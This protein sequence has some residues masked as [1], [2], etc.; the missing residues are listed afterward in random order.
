MASRESRCGSF[1]AAT[2]VLAS[3]A[4][5]QPFS[6]S[7]TVVAYLDSS[8]PGFVSDSAPADFLD[9]L[10]EA[11]LFHLDFG[12][13]AEGARI[14]PWPWLGGSVP[15]DRFSSRVTFSSTTAS[16]PFSSSERVL[17]MGISSIDWEIGPSPGFHGDLEL[18]FEG[19]GAA[20][21]GFGIGTVGFGSD[22]KITLYDS[23][24][25]LL[26]SFAGP[27]GGGFGFAGFV[28]TGAERIARAEIEGGDAYWAIQDVSFTPEPGTGVLLFFG[29]ALLGSR[30]RRR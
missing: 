23:N 25:V 11:S 29:L 16:G 21:R 19:P 12:T 8:V 22:A 17:V 6:A 10:G 9:A 2:L 14:L 1:F 20:V 3:A 24:D 28:S 4:A 13:N 7:A 30:S 5:L 18:D 27:E 15:G 26:G